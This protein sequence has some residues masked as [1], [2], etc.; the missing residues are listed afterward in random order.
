LRQQL[1]YFRKREMLRIIW[2]DVNGSAALMDTCGDL[3]MLADV[4]IEYA[5]AQLT[6]VLPASARHTA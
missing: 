3:S 4:C 5:I 6:P 1:R 2:R